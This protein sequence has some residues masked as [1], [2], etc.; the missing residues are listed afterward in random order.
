MEYAATLDPKCKPTDVKKKGQAAAAA[1][2]G[3][4]QA[5]VFEQRFCLLGD[6]NSSLRDLTDS[7]CSAADFAAALRLQ[8]DC[9]ALLT[10][11]QT[12]AHR[13]HRNTRV[14][15]P[16]CVHSRPHGARNLWRSV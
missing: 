11:S 12:S 8:I 14:A 2:G 7:V 6:D 13:Q 3:K 4:K 5:S 15:L 10:F 16:P 1:G 9:L